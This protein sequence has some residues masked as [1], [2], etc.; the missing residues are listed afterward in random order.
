ME[1]TIKNFS[2]DKVFVMP[3]YKCN[4]RL[5]GS[6]VKVKQEISGV[7][8]SDFAIAA[9]ELKAKKLEEELKKNQQQRERETKI[10]LNDWW[11]SVIDTG[12]IISVCS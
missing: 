6:N 1:D 5:Q 10:V 3:N 12:R 11:W 4:N 9:L 8:D 2:A 7:K